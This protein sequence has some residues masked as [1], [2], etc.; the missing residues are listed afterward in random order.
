M[1]PP[2]L[3]I[4]VENSFVFLCGPDGY[5]PGL[6]V[7]FFKPNTRGPSFIFGGEQCDDGTIATCTGELGSNGASVLERP[8]S[9]DESGC[10]GTGKSVGEVFLVNTLCS[11][12]CVAEDLQISVAKRIGSPFSGGSKLGDGLSYGVAVGILNGPRVVPVEGIEDSLSVPW[13]VKSGHNQ[14][15][16]TQWLY[17][18]CCHLY[19]AI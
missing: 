4:P 17:A 2:E 8:H 10:S 13:T 18:F 11:V 5:I 6:Q 9:L 19:L 14:V 7:P 3:S 16:C 12:H 15:Q 1:S